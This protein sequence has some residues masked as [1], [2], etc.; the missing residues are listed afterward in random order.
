MDVEQV[1]EWIA[2]GDTD[3]IE[4][5]WMEALEAGAP[6]AAMQQTLEALMEAEES[7]TAA[8]LGWILLSESAESRPPAEALRR[9]LQR[10]AFHEACL[11]HPLAD[12]IWSPRG[13]VSTCAIIHRKVNV[14]KPQ[15]KKFLVNAP[16]VCLAANPLPD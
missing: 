15:K 13:V 4:S 12:H 7:E 6:S 10:Q 5:A 14:D 16:A 11:A 8:T 3:A 1:R 9:L 2:D